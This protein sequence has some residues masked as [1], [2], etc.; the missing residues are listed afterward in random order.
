MHNIYKCN[1]SCLIMQQADGWLCRCL[2]NCNQPRVSQKSNIRYAP[3]SCLFVVQLAAPQHPSRRRSCHFSKLHN[4]FI[5]FP[6]QIVS[7]F[8]RQIHLFQTQQQGNR[9]EKPLAVLLGLRVPYE[10]K[11]CYHLCQ[12]R[13]QT[14]RKYSF[15]HSPSER[16]LIYSHI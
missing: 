8:I 13:Q 3:A 16:K 2:H 14:E 11:L 15:R 9:K 7:R 6:K 10:G 1:P 4:L 12:C 5:W